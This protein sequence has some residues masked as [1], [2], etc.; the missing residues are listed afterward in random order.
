MCR[1]GGVPATSQGPP[2][3]PFL[4]SP[5]P[6]TQTPLLCSTGVSLGPAPANCNGSTLQGDPCQWC[7]TKHGVGPQ[8]C[9][10]G[11]R[12]SG[13]KRP[14]VSGS[15]HDG[16]AH[17]RQAHLAPSSRVHVLP[18]RATSQAPRAACPEEPRGS[19]NYG[20][21]KN[22]SS[23]HR[24]RRQLTCT[25]PSRH[26][27]KQTHPRPEQPHMQ[28]SPLDFTAFP[29]DRSSGACLNMK[30]ED[31]LSV[32][33]FKRL[34]RHRFPIICPHLRL[35]ERSASY[36]QEEGDELLSS[37][38]CLIGSLCPVCS[39]LFSS[40]MLLFQGGEVEGV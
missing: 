11:M 24:L 25:A 20:K 26:A 34:Q 13:Q 31:G 30:C 27:R 12:A 17:Q 40:L 22:K 5:F 32:K 16:C 39:E 33:E 10:T 38:A 9:H 19:G 3:R 4:L 14:P 35:T 28:E 23:L 29:Y 7:A 6:S 37:P 15:V 1:P 36:D 21:V 2:Q 8:E 18:G